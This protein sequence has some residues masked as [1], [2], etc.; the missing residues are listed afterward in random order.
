MD[1]TAERSLPAPKCRDYINHKRRAKSM[2]FALLAS[3]EVHQQKT[4][5]HGR[6]TGQTEL[7]VR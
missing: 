7:Q 4:K 3:G 2:L 6:K 5:K 1:T